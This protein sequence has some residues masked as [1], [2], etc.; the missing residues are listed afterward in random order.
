MFNSSWTPL[1]FAAIIGTAVFLL[2]R[3]LVKFQ[4]TIKSDFFVS[5]FEDIG[6]TFYES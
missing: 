6:K 5:Y 4:F 2:I 3:N 1:I